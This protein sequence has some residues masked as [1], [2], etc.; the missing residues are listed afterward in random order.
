MRLNKM[1]KVA[2]NALEEI[3]GQDILVLDVRKLT[4]MC[5]TMIIASAQSTRQVKALARNVRERMEAAGAM[6]IGVEGEESAEWVLVDGGDIVV[7][8]MQPAVRAYY[9]LE[10]LWTAKAGHKRGAAKGP[11]AAPQALPGALDGGGDAI[12]A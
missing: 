4:S 12:A 10:E 1:Q 9:K 11:A 2:V 8:V 6:I 3:K 7:H 5:D